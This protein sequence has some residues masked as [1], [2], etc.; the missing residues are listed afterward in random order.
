[1]TDR[2]GLSATQK[3]EAIQFEFPQLLEIPSTSASGETSL[4]E[5]L[6]SLIHVSRFSLCTLVPPVNT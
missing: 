3:V 5:L 4:D 2:L 1:M 6:S